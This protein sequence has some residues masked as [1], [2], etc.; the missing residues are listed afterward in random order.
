M[1]SSI[2]DILTGILLLGII[3][4][5]GLFVAILINPNVPFN[6]LPPPASAHHNQQPIPT[7]VLPT[8]TATP[9][10]LPPTWTP[11]PQV[12]PTLIRQAA[13]LRPTSTLVPTFTPVILPTFTPTRAAPAAHGGGSCSV[14]AQEP[15]DNSYITAGQSFD[16]QWTL[17]NQSPQV[18]RSDSVD[19]RWVGG[20]KLGVSQTAYDLPY[21]VSP[22]SMLVI[23][24]K[25]VA[26]TQGGAYTSNWAL[27]NGATT[28]CQFYIQ[29]KVP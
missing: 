6:P 14:T 16:V 5:V 1:K 18:W 4:L 11:T 8:A 10:A 24:V 17:K 27:V 23:P 7:I 21:D 15:P 12:E 13:T 26:P 20:D 2:W 29:I 9:L 3:V 19:I 25:M 28:I 22:G